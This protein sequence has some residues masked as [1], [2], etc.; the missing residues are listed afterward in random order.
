MNPEI[1]YHDTVKDDSVEEW[2]ARRF[3]RPAAHRIVLV[4]YDTP[5]HSVHVTWCFLAVGIV[6]AWLIAQ[7]TAA[8]FV[9]AAILIQVKS[10]LDAVD[11]Q[12]ARARMSPSRIGRFFDSAADF[13]T[14]GF[15]IMT[16]AHVAA[17]I[18]GNET[19]LLLGVGAFISSEVQNSF[20]VFYNVRFRSLKEG[21]ARTILDESRDESVYPY[22]EG[23]PA[24]LHFLKTFY[25]IVYG[26]QDGL[27]AIVDSVSKRFAGVDEDSEQRWYGNRFFL[28]TS[29]PLGLGTNLFAMSISLVLLRPV[30]YLFIAFFV[31]NAYMMAL[32][33]YHVVAFRMREK[34]HDLS[35]EKG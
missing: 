27:I 32:I 5:V 22:D 14:Q 10:I 7:A 8:S 25:R 17:K 9:F 34:G 31:G 29:G 26:W 18:S 12:L 21:S 15:L 28:R 20:W 16:C 13:L 4:L 2:I 35:D 19:C 11:G 3:L 23:K 6:A 24:T 33:I 1:S 30:L